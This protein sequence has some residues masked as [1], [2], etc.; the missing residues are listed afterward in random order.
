MDHFELVS[1]YSPT[2]DQPQ[3]IEKLVEG[4]KEGNQFQT[5]LGVTGS[6]KTFTMANVI[7]K[8]NKPTLIIAH[9]KTLAAQLYSEMKEFFPNNAVEYFVSYYDYYQP[10]AYVPSTD[11]YI[12]KDSSINDEIDKLRHSATAA[13]SERQDV[14]IVASVSCIY[15][16]GSPIDYQNMVISLSNILVQSSVN[17]FGADA[18]AGFG[19]YLKIDGF[20]ILP[21]MSISMAVTTF[22]GQNYGAGK[23][24]RVKK[25]MWVTITMGL[26]YTITTGILLLVFSDPLMRLF[27]N[28]DAVVAYGELAMKYF[29]PFYF[30]LSIMHGL[31]GTIRGAGKSV[32]PM[33]VLL[34][35]LCLFRIVWIQ[36]ILPTFHDIDGIFVLYPVSWAFGA[37]LM[38]LYAW[39]GKWLPANTVGKRLS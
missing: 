9:N 18:V 6:G 21:V 20:N 3:A 23:I 27:T 24:D 15:G 32:P 7:Q 38:V 36:F 12:E 33:V 19:A 30:I 26:I 1:E 14:I 37:A 10:E 35:S 8:L 11:T 2:G 34:T 22:T 4:F 31:A 17:G 13:L 29:C 39:K 5:L 25:G 16:L 28:D